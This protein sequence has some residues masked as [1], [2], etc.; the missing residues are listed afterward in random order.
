M[1][2]AHYEE[3]PDSF[4]DEIRQLDQL[5]EVRLSGVCISVYVPI[6]YSVI[7]RQTFRTSDIHLD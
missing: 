6:G 5:R 7:L 2:A 3:N 1:I 4:H